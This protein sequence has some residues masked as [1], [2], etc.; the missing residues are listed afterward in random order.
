[1]STRLRPAPARLA[2]RTLVIVLITA[3]AG[4]VWYSFHLA[5][6]RIYQVDECMEIS[7]ARAIAEG[8]AKNYSGLIP[9]LQLPLSLVIRGIEKSADIF[10]SARFF[11]AE[12]F[13]LNLVL[14]AAATGQ[15]LA[16]YRG[17]LA[18]FFAATL[19]PLWD[20]GFE[21]RHDNPM[22]TGLL[23][24]W[25]LVRVNSSGVKS[26]FL[27]GV[28]AVA[29]QF[30]AHKAFAYTIPLSLAVLVFPPPSFKQPRWKL[31]FAWLVGVILA[32]VALKLMYSTLTGTKFGEQQGEGIS[33]VSSV[34]A[35]S[36]RFWPWV[37]TLPRLLAQTPLLLAL[38]T[39]A[40]AMVLMDWRKRGMAALSW[41]GILPE[42]LLSFGALALLFVNPTPFPY[43]LLHFVPFLFLLAFR[44][45]I[46]IADEPALR[47]KLFPA[48]VAV[49]LFT[50]LV[51][52]SVATRRHIDWS[53]LRQ[54]QLMS[55]AESLADPKKDPVFDGAG[56]VPTRRT[57]SD[58]AFLH[59][60]SFEAQMADT[61]KTVRQ[62]LTKSPAPVLMKNYRTDW[63]SK[64]DRGFIDA[65]YVSL[66]DDFCVL[67]KV[68]PPG[69]GQFE[70]LH[71]G[72]YRVMPLE[73]SNLMGTF[74]GNS[75][76]E[77]TKRSTNITIVARLDGVELGDAPIE[78]KAGI[79]M[80]ETAATEQAAVFWVGPK[81]NE[82]PRLPSGSHRVLFFN[83]Y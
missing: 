6:N 63:L 65:H 68:L 8:G 44:F 81:L 20:Y 56:L 11:M 37:T 26:C 59:S 12:I 18:L 38:A 66:A 67:G 25:C 72:R 36:E 28:L 49:L 30:V 47:V 14:L 77:V 62:M 29:L 50:H 46:S 33:F 39:A 22:L 71:P 4:L 82:L 54:V 32:F 53:N 21:I 34:A 15:K 23:L 79:H 70:V 80:I 41:E 43:N 75:F 1:M 61:N 2:Q 51:P 69:G 73:G 74:D 19:A 5:A 10:V 60:L 16:S 17:M 52:F 58:A 7:I 40:C 42:L 55:Q 45:A 27:I 57:V 76:M 64:E 13:W 24:M 31:V 83:W 48:A 78:L 35:S 3:L 9:L